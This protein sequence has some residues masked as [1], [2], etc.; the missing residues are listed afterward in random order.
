M[1]KDEE[2]TYIDHKLKQGGI[3]PDDEKVRAIKD[4]PVPTD[5]N[6]VERL[7]STVNH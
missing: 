3:K 4:M 7:L 1:F 5:K 6:G 2:V